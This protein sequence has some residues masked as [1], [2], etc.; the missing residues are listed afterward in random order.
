MVAGSQ[1]AGYHLYRPS[2]PH[3]SPQ[4]ELRLSYRELSRQDALPFQAIL[5]S[6]FPTLLYTSAK[7]KGKMEDKETLVIGNDVWFRLAE[8]Y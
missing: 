7:R 5:H 6:S 3:D 4:Q 2:C 8:P 1:L